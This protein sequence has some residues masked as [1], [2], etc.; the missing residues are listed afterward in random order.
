MKP[1]KSTK[2]ITRKIYTHEEDKMLIAMAQYGASNFQIAEMLHRTVR[3][4]ESRKYQLQHNGITFP[5]APKA[6]KTRDAEKQ[7]SDPGK[8]PEQVCM[9]VEAYDF[10]EHMNPIRPVTIENLDPI[11]LVAAQIDELLSREKELAAEL[12]KIR[13][14]KEQIYDKMLDLIPATVLGVIRDVS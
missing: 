14:E 13:S 4:V 8:E 1:T 2:P 9:T 3:S 7:T 6:S 11:S 10:D 5:K 12:E